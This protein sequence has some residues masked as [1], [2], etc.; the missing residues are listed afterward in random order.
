MSWVA[1]PVASRHGDI[2]HYTLAYQALSGEDLERHDV[3]DIPADATSYVLE[4]L[5]KWTEYRVWVRAHTDVG[6]G[7]ESSPTRVWT[8]EDGTLVEPFIQS[9]FVSSQ[10][11]EDLPAPDV[12][13]N[14]SRT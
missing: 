6:A 14:F 12:L 9:F 10:E 13:Q 3:R 2:V 5:E 8:Q 11:L 4:E 7:P 1:P